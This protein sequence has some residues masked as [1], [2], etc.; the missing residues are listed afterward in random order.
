[1]LTTPST[2][3]HEGAIVWIDAH[4]ATI[5][6][7]KA[8][9]SSIERHTSDVPVHR[10]STGHIRH[11]PLTSHGGGASSAEERRRIEHMDRFVDEVADSLA[12][13]EDVV[14]VGP[15]VVHERLE[16][17][18]RELDAKHGRDRTITARSVDRVTEPQLVAQL[19]EHLLA[20]PRR[21]HPRL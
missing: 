1:M 11:D 21:R 20:S 13:D 6:R 7:W 10:R 5:V 2:A 4:K 18:L 8:N 16:T 9:D 19:R 17:R 12:G 3:T 15:G 14:V